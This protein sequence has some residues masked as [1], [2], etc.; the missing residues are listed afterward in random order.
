MDGPNSNYGTSIVG[1]VSGTSISFGSA[2]V[3]N[4]AASSRISS[5]YDANAQ[6]TLIAYSDGGNSNQ[7]TAIIGTISGTSVSF[8]TPVVFSNETGTMQCT[9]ST[10]DSTLQKVIVAY[11]N[12]ADS[13]YG[14]SIVGTIQGTTVSFGEA[15]YINGTN[16]AVNTVLVYNSTENKTACLFKDNGDTYGKGVVLTATNALTI[17]SDYYVQA[18]G[19]LSTTVSSVPAGRALSSTSILLEG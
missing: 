6:K 18:D 15:S 7:G 19:T 4:S 16:I 12:G 8:G 2:V 5:A 11:S 1:T 9:S 3:F 13:F 14:K 10:Y 17:G